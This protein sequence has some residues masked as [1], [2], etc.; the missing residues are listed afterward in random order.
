MRYELRPHEIGWCVWDTVEDCLV[1]A[2]S[3]RS[4]AITVKDALNREEEQR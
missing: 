3:S 1:E 2:T 4:Y